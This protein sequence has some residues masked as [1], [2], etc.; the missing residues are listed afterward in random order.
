MDG[1][2]PQYTREYLDL[3]DKI[4]SDFVEYELYD[5]NLSFDELIESLGFT[6][7]DEAVVCIA[8]NMGMGGEIVSFPYDDFRRLDVSIDFSKV[9]SIDSLKMAAVQT[10]DYYW[11]EFCRR[12]KK[13]RINLTDYDLILRVGDLKD[14]QYLTYE[15]IAEI[16][17]PRDFNFRNEKANP[18]SATRKIGQYYKKYREFVNGGFRDFQYCCR[19]FVQE[20]D[21]SN[22][23]TTTWFFPFVSCSHAV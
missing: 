1:K 3:I 22:L 10:I 13:R 4:A 2:D 12:N 5:P 23:E 7:H 19:K 6:D 16:I 17:F 8:N 21:E 9:N 20:Y 18:E 14:R 15:Q 11:K